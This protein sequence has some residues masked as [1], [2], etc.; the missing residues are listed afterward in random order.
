MKLVIFVVEDEHWALKELVE[1]L[2]K[3]EHQHR[4]FAFENG[5]DALSKM[6]EVIPDLLI[7]DITMPGMTGLELIESALKIESTIKSIILTVHDEFEY[8]RKGIALGIFDYLLKPIK[9]EALYDVI[10]RALEK[11]EAE[12]IELQHHHQWSINQLL[13]SSNPDHSIGNEFEERPFIIT[14]LLLENWKASR[15][16]DSLNIDNETIKA[17]F[18]DDLKGE[19][20]I[21]TIDSQR[22]LLLIPYQSIRNTQLQSIMDGFY[23]YMNQYGMV[24]VSYGVKDTNLS[25]RKAFDDVHKR[26]EMH[27][28]FGQSSLVEQ[29]Q[30]NVDRDLTEIWMKVRILE[31]SLR[32][33]DLHKVQK[34]VGEIIHEVADQRM[35]VRELSQLINNMYYA[36]MYKLT[37]QTYNVEH[38][39]LNLNRLSEFS[40]YI[41]LEEW[42]VEMLSLLSEHNKSMELTPKNLIPKVIDWIKHS[43]QD[44]ITFQQFADDHHVSL[45][46][47]SREFKEQIGVTF[48]EY[49]M[50]FRMNK[51][52]RYFDEGLERSSEVG[53]LV[54]YQDP[55]HFRTVFKKMT[56]MTPRDFLSNRS[57]V[58]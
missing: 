9:R 24:H 7:T 45:S 12:K 5:I 49:L 18:Q 54:G 15:S 37:N 48:S 21:V 20:K 1:S 57:R 40:S 50:E 39:C 10:D 16:W 36:I 2:K 6:E 30:T 17:H 26:L 13:F 44:N 38:S 11:I 8:A 14:Y 3:Y 33:G 35:T 22:K 27:L 55:K 41:E 42:L 51:A 4:I 29:D 31:V 25:L 43:Y 32:N 47:L 52:K 58:R 53:Y 19:M 23:Q 28:L 34:Q 46:Y 56:G